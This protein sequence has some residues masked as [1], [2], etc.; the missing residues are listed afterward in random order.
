MSESKIAVAS[1][2]VSALSFFL[3]A[4]VSAIALR[5]SRMSEVNLLAT[6]REDW[7]DLNRSWHR[8]ILTVNGPGDYYSYA[9]QDLCDEY[10]TYIARLASGEL[11]E[12]EGAI[13][14]RPWIEAI[15]DVVSF[16]GIVATYVLR[17]QISAQNAYVIFG[18]E[19]ARRSKIVRELLDEEPSGRFPGSQPAKFS[20][21][22]TSAG[23]W[24]QDQ[25][26]HAGQ[27]GGRNQRILCLQDI[28]WSQ[29][30]RLQDLYMY[31]IEAAARIKREHGSGSRARNRVRRLCRQ[32]GGSYLTSL[33]LQWQ[34]TNSEVVRPDLNSGTFVYDF[35]PDSEVPE[36]LR[37]T[38]WRRLSI[39]AKDL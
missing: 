9:D 24:W 22:E 19:V 20:D 38:R 34:L 39:F 37:I 31:E 11:T 18:A 16:F 35:D 12:E 13:L 30:A 32:L 29:A 2:T 15:N 23:A 10:D 8:S 14:S 3:S 25:R 33:R 27:Y 1:L 5:N 36:D 26:M 7:K 21:E 17:G 4:G 6:L 28:I